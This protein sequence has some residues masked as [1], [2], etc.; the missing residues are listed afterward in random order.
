MEDLSGGEPP[1]PGA[2]PGASRAKRGAAPPPEAAVLELMAAS[3]DEA[4]WIGTSDL[5]RLLYVSPAFERIWGVACRDALESAGLMAGA[6]H[7]DD[8]TRFLLEG[9]G[10]GR[11]V[12][13]QEV[14]IIRGDGAIRWVRSRVR[15]VAGM[16]GH[17]ELLAG[18][19]AD[20]TERKLFQKALIESHARLATI[21]DSIAAEVS[22]ADPQADEVLFVNRSL[23][24]SSPEVRVGRSAAALPPP[25]AAAGGAPDGAVVWEDHDPQDGRA[26]MLTERDIRWV[27]GRRVRLRIAAD[28][29]RLKALEA[30]NLK[31]QARLQQ[32]QKMEAIGTLAAG[33]AHDFNNVLSAVIGYGEIAL[34]ELDPGAAV[35]RHI[36]EILKAGGRA[37]DLVKQILTF[38]RQD[39]HAHKPI[40]LQPLIKETVNFLRASLPATIAIRTELASRAVVMADA[41][42]IQQVIINLCTNAAHA[43]GARGGELRI[44]LED[45]TLGADPRPEYREL[46]PGAYQRLS[47]ADTGRGIDPAI[48]PRIF[49]PFFTTKTRGEGTGMGLAVVLGIVQ[50][51]GGAVA[52]ESE[53]GRGTRF[54]ILLPVLP[55]GLE[56][57]AFVMLPHLPGGRERI[58]FV[59]DEEPLAGLGREALERLGYRVTALS[60]SRAALA[61]FRADPAGFDLV[62]SD[63][64]MPHMTGEALASEMLRLRPDLPVVLCSGYRERLAAGDAAPPGVRA[65][66]LKPVVVYE[67]AHT[68]RRV[69]D[70]SAGLI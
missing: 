54:E 11:A 36:N 29:T 32:A 49:E 68:V 3:I 51:H 46:A 28:V 30:E 60:D 9:I 18:S 37:R 8:R 15:R 17:A 20:V 27:D 50:G 19:S 35:R 67:L 31:I 64:T 61:V 62:V 45:A 43:M 57:D 44:G 47:V 23:R 16:R 5:R 39:E 2:A 10:S 7:P 4:F 48:L 26:R 59:D 38:S 56:A 13:E 6:V 53:V 63:L 55:C 12:W 24:E 70:A 25:P 14:R 41:T 22:V 21:L 52:V 65:F 34:M 58:L 42:Q 69:L 1:M 33:I 66:L 40:Q